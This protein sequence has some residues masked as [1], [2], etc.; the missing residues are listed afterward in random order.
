MKNFLE[1]KNLN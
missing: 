1:G